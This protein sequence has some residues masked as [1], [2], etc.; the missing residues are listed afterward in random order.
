MNI[1]RIRKN[2]V[3]DYGL[4]S[5]NQY[6]V[7]FEV[8]MGVNAADDTTLSS[9]MRN[10]GFNIEGVSNPEIFG[11]NS[12]TVT[13]MTKLSFLADEIGIPGYSVATG[14]FKGHVPGINARYAHTRNFTEMNV[15]F[16]MDMDHTPLKFLR[17]WSDYIFGFEDFGYG[18]TSQTVFSQLQYYNNYTHDIIIDKLEPN[19]SGFTKSRARSSLET[20]NVVTRTRLHKAFPYMIN[21]VTLSNAPNQPMR[22]QSTF[23][24]EYFTTENA[25]LGDSSPTALSNEPTIALNFLNN[26]FLNLG[27]SSIG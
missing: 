12:N 6:H 19:T 16:L 26:G 2:I 13:N 9:F 27:S 24:Y 22:L 20:H 1:D 18:S 8:P 11:S 10:R 17:L 5:S 15:T 23:Y 7:S 14:D 21:D 25:D 3:G 4:S